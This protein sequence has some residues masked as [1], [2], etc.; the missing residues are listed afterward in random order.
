MVEFCM[1]VESF[2]QLQEILELI[3]EEH[4]LI[5]ISCHIF[6]SIMFTIFVRRFPLVYF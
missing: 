5:I 3:G 1:E 4:R 2:R 6:A